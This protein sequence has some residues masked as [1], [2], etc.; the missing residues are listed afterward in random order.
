MFKPG[1][2]VHGGMSKKGMKGLMG[3]HTPPASS[4]PSIS[5]KPQHKPSMQVPQVGM[6]GAKCPTCGQS[7]DTVDNDGD[8]HSSY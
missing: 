1:Q 7:M 5:A 3:A 2:R 8:F 6:N 4:S